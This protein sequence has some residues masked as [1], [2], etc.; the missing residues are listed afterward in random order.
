MLEQFI[1]SVNAVIPLFLLIALGFVLKKNKF[2]YENFIMDGNKFV[3]QVLLPIMLFNNVYTT[4]LNTFRNFKLA[5]VA[6]VIS[7]FVFGAVWACA[8]LFFE[9][10]A[11]LGSFVQGAFRANTAFIGVP[12]MRNIAGDAGIANFAFIL[13]FIMPLYNIFTILVFSACNA[14]G[15]KIKL[16]TIFYTICKNPLTVSIFVGIIF[17]LLEI[18]I[19]HTINRSLEDLARM[20]TPM[21]LICLGGGIKFLGFDKKFKYAVVGSALKIILSP[22]IFLA[23]GYAFG[24]RDIE[25]VTITILGGLPS[26]IIGYVMAVEM[27]GDG[28]VASNIVLISTLLSSVTLT[29]IVYG[30]MA[31]GLL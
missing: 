26:A 19:P 30:M 17:S 13:V 18:K 25:L 14:S 21:A 2:I 29:F 24:L 7:V 1:F 10:K 5:A 15:E 31:A 8:A 4:D 11:I 16:K 12:L 3:L 28:Y 23:A 6:V 9:S 22:L 27:G 20:A